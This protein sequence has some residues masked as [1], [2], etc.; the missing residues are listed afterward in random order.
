MA[1]HPRKKKK[2]NTPDA[3]NES[4]L[5]QPIRMEKYI[6]TRGLKTIINNYDPAPASVRF[7]LTTFYD[8]SRT[9]KVCIW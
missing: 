3:K 2:K 9:N 7:L 6:V 4:G 8:I 1:S 5:I